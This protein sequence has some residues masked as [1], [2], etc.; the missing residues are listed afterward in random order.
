M[1]QLIS[2]WR[3]GVMVMLGLSA[4]A[5]DAGAYGGGRAGDPEVII[6]W[7][8]LLESVQ[9]A[10][11]LAHP[12]QYAM[13]HIAMF[14]AINSITRTHRPYKLRVRAPHAACPDIA[15]AQAA[16]DVL[17]AHFPTAQSTFDAALQ[18]RV[19]ATP[20]A[21][22]R[23]SLEVGKA[24]AAAIL[25]WRANDGWTVVAEPFVQPTFPGLYQP[26]PPNFTAATFRQFQHTRPFALLTNTQYLPA[27]PPSLASERYAASFNEAKLLGAA[28]STARTAEQTQLAQLFGNITSRTA[29]WA[30]WNH[31]ARDTA[32]TT[33]TS[34]IDTARLFALLNVSIHDGLQTSHSSKFV[35]GVW[36]P[37]TAIHRADEDQNAMT[38][39][40]TTWQPLLT[41][42]PYPSHAGNMACVGASAARALALFHGT[43]EMNFNALWQGSS[44]QPDVTR[45]YSSFWQLAEDQA[46]SRIYAGIHFRFES[47]VSQ[48]SCPKVAEYVFARF[49]RAKQH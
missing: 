13:L 33:R 2:I 8:E 4:T 35:Y 21:Q 23:P 9:P 10:G 41:T 47:E 14:D 32:R 19:K 46:N 28:Q 34:L 45:P 49:M 12:R 11:G 6:E 16:R 26:T 25:A 48:E 18:A 1:S 36:R 31:V 20:S 39:A 42:P 15:A 27:A 5:V 22:V 37:I 38:D 3:I 7:N 40:D 29:H 43:D 17:V 30:I 44:G 24:V